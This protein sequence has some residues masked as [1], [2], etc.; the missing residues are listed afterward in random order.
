MLLGR[1]NGNYLRYILKSGSDELMI[2]FVFA[3]DLGR[4]SNFLVAG[5]LNSVVEGFIT[6]YYH[7]H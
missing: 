4:Y 5:G 1:V 2:E 3:F 6:I 7:H